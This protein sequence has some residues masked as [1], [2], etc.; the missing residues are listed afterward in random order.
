MKTSNIVE[1]F[2][3]ALKE[4]RE[5]ELKDKVTVITKIFNDFKRRKR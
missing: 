1:A 2:I 5:N 4:E 3:E